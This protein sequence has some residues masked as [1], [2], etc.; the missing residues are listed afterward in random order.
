MGLITTSN[1][2]VPTITQT[3]QGRDGEMSRLLSAALVDRQFC[4]R[5]LSE[6]DLALAN[7]YNGESFSLSLKERQFV[8]STQ[9][10]S[11]PDLAERWV[12]LNHQFNC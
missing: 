7:G 2:F 5:L 9:F 1:V 10:N 11:L 8:L 3:D 4:E 6:P 12:T